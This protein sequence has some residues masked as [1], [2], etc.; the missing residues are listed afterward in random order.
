ML[1][2]SLLAA[3]SA[4]GGGQVVLVLGAGCSKEP[5]TS[6]PL[7]RECAEEAHRRLVADHVL[8]QNDCADPAD[9]SLLAE[10]VFEKTGSQDALVDRMN[11]VK[12]R[13]APP[14]EGYQLAAAL[15]AEHAISAILT[16]N[17][18]LAI[19][20]AI[21]FLGM[22]TDISVILGP[23]DHGRLSTI[24]VVYLHRSAKADPDDWILRA[25]EIA[26]G[27][28]GRWEQVVAQRFLLMPT[29]VFVGLGSP[30]RVLIE[31]VK[32][33]RNAIP[34]GTHIF[35]VDVARRVD[36]AFVA[37]LQLPE[38][39]FIQMG[40]RDFVRQLAVRLSEEHRA[41]LQTACQWLVQNQGVP[42]ENVPALCERIVAIGLLDFGSLRASW[43]LEEGSYFPWRNTDAR[44]IADLLLAVGFMERETE[45]QAFFE[46]DG[47]VE[48]RRGSS[49]L[50][51]IIFAS[52]RGVKRWFA[53]EAELQG[54]KHRWGVRQPQPTAAIF[55]GVNGNVRAAA[56]PADISG[57]V[58]VGD[59]VASAEV[60]TMVTVD[61]LR[62]TE[63]LARELLSV[64]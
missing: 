39:S 63:G 28:Q 31:T 40:W 42:N 46:H 19:F 36:S 41:Q 12:F 9:L 50:G 49:I 52:G 38:S 59:I 54:D 29:V 47:V 58:E 34:E 35:Q 60:L 45:A 20:H 62:N 44:L 24:N 18:D 53:M 15:L 57:E 30:A 10:V 23:E 64:V 33:I 11:P 14:N 7:S 48:F 4:H 55:A 56:P 17:F 25:T 13:Q 16:L 5:P 37:E 26:T 22:G 61:D 32:L 27:W 1:P 43:L 6:L 51:R 3:I 8:G 21:S 2:T